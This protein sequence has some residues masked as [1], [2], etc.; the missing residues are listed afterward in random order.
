[1]QQLRKKNQMNNDNDLALNALLAAAIE[2]DP[3]LDLTLLKSSYE[4]QKKHQ[5][6]R[7]DYREASMQELKN[8]IEA[9][10]DLEN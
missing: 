1:M 10:I 7:D 2:V 4:I 8:L 3:E 6:D 9:Q 5:F